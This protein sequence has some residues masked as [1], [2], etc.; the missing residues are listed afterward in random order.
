MMAGVCEPF[1]TQYVAI[2]HENVTTSQ[3]DRIDFVKYRLSKSKVTEYLQCPKRL[4][5]SV[6]H[7]EL[8][9]ESAD[10]ETRFAVGHQVGELACKL[11]PDGIMIGDEQNDLRAALAQTQQVLRDHP[12]KP[13]FEATFQHGGMLIRADLLIPEDGNYRMVEVKSS[14]SV[15][16]YHLPDCAMQSW[17]MENNGV[18]LNRVALMRIDSS[19]V[20]KHL[21]D[22]RELLLEEDITEV[23]Q[24]I[25]QKVPVWIRDCQK[26]LEGSEP[27]I[28]IGAQ[29][30]T[31]FDCPFYG[32]CSTGQP[33]Y[34]VTLLP[35]N[36][37]RRGTATML[38]ELGYQ[39]LRNVPEGVID[40]PP[41]ERIRRI[42]VDGVAELDPAVR[43]VMAALP[44][45]RYY[46]D[47]ETIQFSVPVW[48]RTRPFQQIPFQWSC[49]IESEDGSL[50]HYEFLDLSG[51][52]PV[53]TFCEQMVTALD[54]DGPILVYSQGFE[55]TRIREM[56]EMFSEVARQI[57]GL[58]GHP[59]WY[60]CYDEQ[61]Q[62]NIFMSL[63][64]PPLGDGGRIQCMDE[65]HLKLVAK[66]FS[67]IANMLDAI[68]ERIVDLLPIAKL[69]YYHPS[70]KGSWSI[71]AVL[72]T[73]APDL[74]YGNLDEV[75]DGGMAQTAFLEAVSPDTAPERK[76]ILRSALLKYC[77]RDTLALVRLARFF[78]NCSAGDEP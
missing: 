27:E 71:K 75:R 22:Y 24:P 26:L 37:G 53:R 38:K 45:P 60:K 61:R 77:E 69:Y 33:E 76:E 56:S 4:Y 18:R 59:E 34:P 5:L 30:S 54:D 2:P 78:A 7:P 25:K 43:E 17:V 40:S 67:N 52:F 63:I 29:C 12:G 21:G 31:P 62:M 70:M 42:T 10:M 13:V 11:Y 68:N 48:L 35:G 28:E 46:L 55:K 1:A 58:V 49:H 41:L 51:E 50:D 32:H 36:M 9:E 39:D 64:E 44:Y 57:E 23:I 3:H 15:K 66:E 6:H 8:K 19:F 47:F 73:I 65:A 20:Y 16:D 74:D 14:T 72:P